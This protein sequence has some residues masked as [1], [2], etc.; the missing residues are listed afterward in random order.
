MFPKKFRIKDYAVAEISHRDELY[1]LRVMSVVDSGL[2]VWK[3][4]FYEDAVI[5]MNALSDGMSWKP[6]RGDA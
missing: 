3:F 6:E 2:C 1:T 4:V 5:A